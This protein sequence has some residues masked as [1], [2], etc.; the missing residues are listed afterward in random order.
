M[1]LLKLF[2][3]ILIADFITGIVHWFED[4]YGNPNWKYLGKIMVVPNLEHHIKPTEFLKNSFWY[5]IRE[6]F[7]TS[8]ILLFIFWC[9]SWINFYT[10]FTILYMS[11]ANQF[12]AIT[13]RTNEQ[14][15]W[16]IELIQKTGLIQN[17]KMHLEHHINPYN[18]NYCVMTGYL[19]PILN[20]FKFWERLEKLVLFFGIKTI[21]CSEIRGGY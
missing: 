2:I 20:Y 3:C 5:R 6:S 17:R 12:H 15:G 7:F 10:T 14:N 19:N 8:L 21:R 1:F 13:H 9:F 4:A 18:I 16:V 11:L